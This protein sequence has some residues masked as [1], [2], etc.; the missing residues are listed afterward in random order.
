MTYQLNMNALS[1]R[2]SGGDIITRTRT[3]TRLNVSR[4]YTHLQVESSSESLNELNTYPLCDSASDMQDEIGIQIVCHVWSR[5]LLKILSTSVLTPTNC[6]LI[7][8]KKTVF[9]I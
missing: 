3:V 8:V 9:L 6:L 4:K 2:S 5:R 7:V 1:T